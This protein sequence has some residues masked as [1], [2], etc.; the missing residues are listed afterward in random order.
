[1]MKTGLEIWEFAIAAAGGSIWQEPKTLHLSGEAIF[2]PYGSPDKTLVFDTYEMYRVF[3]SENQA[4]HQANGK[5]RFDAAAGQTQ[6]FQLCFD[7]KQSNVF[8]SDLAKPYADHF[9]WSN[10]F[11]FGIFR[12]ANRE[13]FSIE[14]LIDDQVEGFPCYV[15]KITDAK[16]TETFFSIDQ[17]LGFIRQ[18]GFSTELGW[19]HRTY[20]IFEKNTNGF[21]Q[22]EKI[23]IYFSGIKWMDIHWQRYTVNLPISDEIFTLKEKNSGT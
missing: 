10:N 18:V 7:G 14:R 9:K 6:F 3:P 19:H 20:D 5:V 12:F 13:G 2:T 4:A 1:M 11:G 22:P 16:Q 8:L 23:R 17:E 15:L 21:I